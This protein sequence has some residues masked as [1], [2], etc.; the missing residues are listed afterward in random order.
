[1]EVGGQRRGRPK[2]ETN[3]GQVEDLDT[4]RQMGRVF[5]EVLFV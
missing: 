5:L 1:M 2:P 4:R 3:L